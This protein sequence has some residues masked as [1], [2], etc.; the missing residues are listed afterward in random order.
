MQEAQRVDFT[1]HCPD[2]D[3]QN[4]MEVSTNNNTDG[5]VCLLGIRRLLRSFYTKR[6]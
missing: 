2:A 5:V 1:L 4:V 6:F 3:E